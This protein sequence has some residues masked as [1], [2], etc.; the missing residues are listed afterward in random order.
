MDFAEA[1]LVVLAEELEH[2]RILTVDQRDFSIY[3]WKE[4]NTFQNL[5]LPD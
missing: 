5:L 3:R 4:T 1:S 2:G